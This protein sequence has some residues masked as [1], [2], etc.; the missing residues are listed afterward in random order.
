MA[1]AHEHHH[2]HGVSTQADGRKLAVALTLILGFMAFEVAAGLLA[3][4]LALLSDAAH[5]LTDAA[6]IGL[7]L[8]AIRL[9]ARP[10]GGQMTFGLKRAEILSAQANGVTL[11]V[12]GLLIVAEGIRRVVTAP[13]VHGGA[14]LV[15]ALVGI[16]VNLAATWT[17]SRANRRSMNVDGA[18]RHIVTDLA[19]FLFTAVAGAVILVTGFTRADGVASLIVAA[20]MLRAAYGLLK[21]SGRVFLEA[22]PEDLDVDALGRDLAEQ[23]G[24]VEVHD[25]HV[26]EVTSGF[27]SLS[28]HVVVGEADD[29]HA[30]RRQLERLL[31]ERFDIEHTTLQ[32]DHEGGEL[33]SIEAPGDGLRTPAR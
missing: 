27:P 30:T 14:V 26:W 33:L 8:V 21:A 11:L 16:V 19:A 22:A 6:A 5:M 28:A 32:V 15:V 12:L 1:G 3:H 29:C 23:P 25:L 9:A 13:A 2:A 18:F 10:A 7:S 24:V 31:F 4:S 17:L 20:I